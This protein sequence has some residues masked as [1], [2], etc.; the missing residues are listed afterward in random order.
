MYLGA[1]QP[2]KAL[3][4]YNKA[5]EKDVTNAIFYIGYIYYKGWESIERSFER[6]ADYISQYINDVPDDAE[7]IHLLERCHCFMQNRDLHKA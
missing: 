2:Q 4:S 1:N 3:E 5:A 7:T 6:T